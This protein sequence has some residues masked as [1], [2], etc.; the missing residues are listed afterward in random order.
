MGLIRDVLALGTGPK[1]ARLLREDT[2]FSWQNYS[3]HSATLQDVATALR[4]S[5]QR[6]P[7]TGHLG[8]WTDSA[9]GVAGSLDYNRALCRELAIAY[10]LIFDLNQTECSRAVEGDTI[11]F[12]GS[13]VRGGNRRRLTLLSWDGLQFRP[14]PNGLP[15]FV[16]FLRV[17]DFGVE[18]P[19][20]DL[21]RQSIVASFGSIVRFQSRVIRAHLPAVRSHLH[22]IVTQLF[23]SD[24]RQRLWDTLADRAVDR[25]GL[26]RRQR[27]RATAT[28]LEIGN[29][30][31][32]R[33]LDM[34]DLLLLPLDVADDPDSWHSRMGALPDETPLLS[35]HAV[36][37]LLVLCV[38][39]FRQPLPRGR[40][41]ATHVQWGAIGLAG[42]PPPR[43]S[44]FENNRKRVRSL[45][46][47][48][49]TNPATPAGFF[50]VLPSP[51]FLLL[52]HAACTTDC[53]LV[54][55]LC[56]RFRD[57]SLPP[58]GPNTERPARISGLVERVIGPPD[59]P[60][61]SPYFA[62]RFRHFR[63][64]LHGCSVCHEGDLAVLPEVMDLTLAA[65]SELTG[66]LWRHFCPS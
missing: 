66:Y 37:A 39:Q 54:S 3:T 33:P 2:P 27:C 19:L 20:A 32:Q 64:P 8:N 55:E 9:N 7:R 6:L 18:M 10:P 58:L 11:Y 31:I 43:K 23:Q 14:V 29:R 62:A 40:N 44:Y 12:P 47:L 53:E 38:P 36:H 63:S 1:W 26:V 57:A 65:A 48:L 5:G 22:V 28:G 59:R 34:V 13:V 4:Q 46:D 60:R 16:P 50:G 24:R 41:I 17:R 21:H 51:P 30:L 15:R 35:N 61:L 45:F 25:S 49:T 52:P 56:T 42:V